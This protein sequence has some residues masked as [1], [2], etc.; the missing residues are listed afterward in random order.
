MPTPASAADPPVRHRHRRTPRRR[1]RQHLAQHA[2]VR[3]GDRRQREALRRRCRAGGDSRRRSVSSVSTR[4]SAAA[5]A[6]GSCR[7]TS[8]PSTPSLHDVARAGRAG[9][10]DRHAARHR[11]DQHV[12]EPFVARR[13]R[14]HVGARDVLPRI[15]SESRTAPPRRRDRG[16]RRCARIARSSS[17]CPR[18]NS[19]AGTRCAQQRQRVDQQ[20]IVLRFGQPAG[21]DD[22]RP[23]PSRRVRGIERL[24]APRRRR[25]RGRPG[26]ARPGCGAAPRR[27]ASTRSSATPCDVVTIRSAAA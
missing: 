21:G 20:R 22:H 9:R 4:S 3:R 15:A 2:I 1:S 10:D 24:A 12:A 27:S 13:Q 26:C 18:M 11:L 23:L 7:S 14:E 19:R 6:A 8:R 25:R 5:T 17:P 16:R